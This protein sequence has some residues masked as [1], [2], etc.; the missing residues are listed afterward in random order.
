MR[1]G[2]YD[3]LPRPLRDRLLSELM[4]GQCPCLPLPKMESENIY[5]CMGAGNR[6]QLSH[7]LQ[8][9]ILEMNSSKSNLEDRPLGY[10]IWMFDLS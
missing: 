6:K 8:F 9:L 1:L 2:F 3:I 4:G 7:F 10:Q 5:G